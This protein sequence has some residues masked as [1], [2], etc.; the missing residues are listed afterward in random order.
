MNKSNIMIHENNK[1][2]KIIIITIVA[3]TERQVETFKRCPDDELKTTRIFISC[4]RNLANDETKQYITKRN[5]NRYVL[6]WLWIRD[7]KQLN[8]NKE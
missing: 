5:N 6:P 8:E 7:N 1:N 4:Q 3:K 2:K